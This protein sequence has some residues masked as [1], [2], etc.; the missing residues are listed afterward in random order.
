MKIERECSPLHTHLFIPH[1]R[2]R[3]VAVVSKLSLVEFPSSQRTGVRCTILLRIKTVFRWQHAEWLPLGPMRT[4]SSPAAAGPSKTSIIFAIECAKFST[5][6]TKPFA[7]PHKG[8]WK[9][10]KNSTGMWSCRNGFEI[11][12]DCWTEDDTRP[13]SAR[14]RTK[15]LGD[16]E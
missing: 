3:L 9:L 2:M 1:V 8:A 16:L 14:R 10:V 5:I 11:F 15:H 4:N 6:R 7:E 13:C 12:R